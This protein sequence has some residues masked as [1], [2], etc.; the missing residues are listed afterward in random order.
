[1]LISVFTP[2]YNRAY[3]IGDLYESLREQTFRDFEWVI[4]DDGSQDETEDLVRKWIADA[5][6]TI[7]YFRQ[8]N[9][10]KHIAV[11]RGMKEARGELFYIVDSDD[12][13]PQDALQIIAEEYGKV[14]G[15]EDFCGVSGARYYPNGKRIGGAASF[16]ILEC[17]ALDFR[18]KYHVPGDMAEVFR[19]EILRRY[20]FPE[21]EGEKFCPEAL[22]WNRMAEKYKLRYFNRCTYICEYLPDGLTAGIV[23]ARRNSPLASMT[24][25]SEQAK[26]NVPLREKLKSAVNFWRFADRKRSAPFRFNLLL[27]TVA[28]LPGRLMRY[29]D[30]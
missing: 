26:R 10:G 8:Y 2:T 16:G 6:F 27:R 5:G 29:K 15:K 18:Q 7:R 25:Y 11:N 21:F 1:M 12:Y 19:T 13:L 24:Y 20:P 4:V 30:K 23:R 9:G 22:V 3:R 17:S 28:Y 14:R